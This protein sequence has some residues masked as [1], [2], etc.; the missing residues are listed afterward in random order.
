M[1]SGWGWVRGGGGGG[2]IHVRTSLID[3]MVAPQYRASCVQNFDSQLQRALNYEDFES[4]ALIRSKRQEVT[5]DPLIHCIIC[6]VVYVPEILVRQIII[7]FL[8][9]KTYRQHSYHH[10]NPL[11]IHSLPHPYPSHMPVIQVLGHFQ[12]V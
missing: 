9:L 5:L 4:A 6:A 10:I 2:L 8:D 7:H 11:Q 1:M 3:L 12:I